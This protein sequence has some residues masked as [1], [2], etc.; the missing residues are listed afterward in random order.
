[1]R[2]VLARIRRKNHQKS[3]QQAGTNGNAKKEVRTNQIG[4]RICIQVRAGT[5][6]IITGE[7]NVTI[8]IQTTCR[9]M[10]AI[11]CTPLRLVEIV[12]SS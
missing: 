10:S 3:T 9:A 6:K 12:C 4:G 1:M 8:H 11:T 2:K 7:T 5:A